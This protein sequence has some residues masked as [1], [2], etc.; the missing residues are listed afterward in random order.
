MWGFPVFISEMNLHNDQKLTKFNWGARLGQFIGFLGEHSSLVDNLR[1]QSTGF[2]LH[3][4][5]WFLMIYLERLFSKEIMTVKLKQYA[6]IF[7]ISIRIGMPNR[8]LTMLVI[9]FMGP[10]PF[11]MSK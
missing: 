7:L 4:F 10:H 5:I 11:T 3:N 6:V 1:H 9:S 2:F 8:S